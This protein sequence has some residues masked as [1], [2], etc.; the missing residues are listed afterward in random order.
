MRTKTNL[1]DPDIEQL[2]RHLACWRKA[3]HAPSPI[4]PSLWKRA[5]ELATRLGVCRTARALRLDYNA[6]KRRVAAL[7]VG[8]GQ[9]FGT[10]RGKSCQP[11]PPSA[12]PTNATFL[13]LLA[14][15]SATIAECTMA[16]ESARGAKLRIDMRGVPATSVAAVVREF[17]Q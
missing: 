5:A 3:H 10:S 16:L 8:Q 14:P 11:A 4:P 9:A 17:I 15:K 7:P 12:D 2:S 13:E 6:L 1:T